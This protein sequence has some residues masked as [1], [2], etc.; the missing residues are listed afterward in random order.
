V[1]VAP[2]VFVLHAQRVVRRL[3][4]L[5]PAI[6]LGCADSGAE[7]GTLPL[8]VSFSLTQGSTSVACK[9]QPGVTAAEIRLINPNNGV[10]RPGYPMP[11][12]CAT[13][14]FVGAAPAGEHIIEIAALGPLGDSDLGTIFLAHSTITLP[15]D[16]PIALA[17]TPQVAFLDLAWDFGNQAGATCPEE[18]DH[19]VLTVTAP[20]TTTP[21]FSGRIE[22]GT[23]SPKLIPGAFDL[24]TYTIDLRA[25]SEDGSPLYVHSASRL[26]SRGNNEYS[27]TLTPRGGRIYLDWDFTI[28]QQRIRA[29]G[30]PAVAVDNL[31]IRVS[32]REG[33]QPVEEEVPCSTS[34]PYAFRPGR[35]LPARQLTLELEAQGAAHFTVSLPFTMPQGDYHSDVLSLK[36]RGDVTIGINVET[37]SCAVPGTVFNFAVL[38]ADR[39]PLLVAEQSLNA[40]S[41]LAAFDALEYGRYFVA[42]EAMTP[43][44]VCTATGLRTVDAREHVWEPLDL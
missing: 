3:S 35:F 22:C 17:L 15:S 37:A 28:D 26:F 39:Q 41:E 36:A 1:E 40:S 4:L 9:D 44:G 23:E 24:T 33:D 14:T 8:N 20:G 12:D 13:G 29:C 25:V 32:S 43:S 42:L 34:R 19:L 10:A 30:D 21:A 27:A 38:T 7:S 31:I 11:A 16:A 6:L 5:V 18:V 2:V